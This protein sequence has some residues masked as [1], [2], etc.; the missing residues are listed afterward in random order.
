MDR[1]AYKALLDKI[2]SDSRHL[3]EIQELLSIGP[4]R[5]LTISSSSIVVEIEELNCKFVWEPG[6]PRTAVAALVASGK[7]EST[8]TTLLTYLAQ[9]SNVILDIGANVGYYAVL[10]GLEIGE[11]GQVYSFEPLPSSFSQLQT[12]VQINNL[13]SKVQCI[14]LAL[15]DS[16]GF[17]TLHVP[18]VSGTSATSMQNLHPDEA[19]SS[20]SIETQKLDD[21]V[22][23]RDIGKIDLIKIDVEGAERLVFQGGWQSIQKSLPVIFAEL[24]RKWS[25]GFG[26]H[27]SQVV[28]EFKS[29]GYR[30]FA[31]GT[32]LELVENITEETEETN[33]LFLTNSPEH[34]LLENG[35]RSIGL[36]R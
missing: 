7:Y 11:T 6:D 13:D 10:L 35:L 2:A 18:K 25:A 36:I 27:P 9:H 15:S 28:D 21:V 17:A 32:K 16:S 20:F 12:N 26:Y 14:S 33:F 5:T 4:T 8:E 23:R 19:N 34:S 3:V 29:L 1:E 31:V 24:L 30:C 22:V